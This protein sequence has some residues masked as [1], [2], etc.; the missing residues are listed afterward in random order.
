MWALGRA[1]KQ[2]PPL[3][4]PPAFLCHMKGRSL[5]FQNVFK[6]IYGFLASTE[7]NTYHQKPLDSLVCANICW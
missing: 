5:L 6:G 7:T 1:D 3:F 2:E 4:I